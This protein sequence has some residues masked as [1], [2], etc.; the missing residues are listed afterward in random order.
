MFT[1]SFQALVTESLDMQDYFQNRIC[2]AKTPFSQAFTIFENENFF[3]KLLTGLIDFA[4]SLL[5]IPVLIVQYAVG[6]LMNVAYSVLAGVACVFTPLLR[7]SGLCRSDDFKDFEGAIRGAFI[8][9]I[10]ET[11]TNV[12]DLVFEPLAQALTVVTRTLATLLYMVTGGL[13]LGSEK[14]ERELIF[15]D[16]PVAPQSITSSLE[17]SLT[18]VSTVNHFLFQAVSSSEESASEQAPQAGL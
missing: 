11:F 6:F 5:R 9:A 2:L 3:T 8:I 13:F 17:I 14:I 15:E 16:T 10:I 12:F 1:E 7:L 4:I 18:K